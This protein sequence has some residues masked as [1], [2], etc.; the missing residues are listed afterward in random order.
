MNLNDTAAQNGGQ[1]DTLQIGGVGRRRCGQDRP[2]N[3]GHTALFLL[4]ILD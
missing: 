3:S 1:D 2:H 4:A